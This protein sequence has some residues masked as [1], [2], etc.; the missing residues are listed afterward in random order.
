MSANTFLQSVKRILLFEEQV[1]KSK[2]WLLSC[3]PVVSNNKCCQQVFELIVTKVPSNLS[4]GH[5]GQSL[6]GL[7]I[8]RFQ[9]ALSRIIWFLFFSPQSDVLDGGE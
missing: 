5:D 6:D 7:L 9:L 8:S 3:C 4:C 1:L 2:V